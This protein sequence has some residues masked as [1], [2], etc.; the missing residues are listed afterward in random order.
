[1]L[2]RLWLYCNKIVGQYS[3]LWKLKNQGFSQ[4]D[5]ESFLTAILFTGM[6]MRL[7]SLNAF[8]LSMENNSKF[9]VAVL[10]QENRNAYEDIKNRLPKNRPTS[11]QIKEKLNSG[12]FTNSSHGITW[13]NHFVQ[14]H[15]LRK[16]PNGCGFQKKER[17]GNNKVDMAYQYACHL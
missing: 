16:G 7:R 17:G 12:T 10:K 14:W 13:R 3:A 2:K 4:K 11:I 9:W 1:M 8:K 5:N 15:R 6:F